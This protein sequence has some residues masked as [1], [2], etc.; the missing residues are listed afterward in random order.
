MSKIAIITNIPA[1]YRVDLF[2]YLQT[3]INEH[4]FHVIYTSAGEDNRAWTV[5]EEKMRNTRIL[6]TRVV[7]LRGKLDT[8]YI[9]LPGNVGN[10]LN[11]L[12]PDAV[13]AS[14]YNPAAMQ[15]LLW[16]K[17]HRKK[18]IHW[19]DGTLHSERNIGT[20]Q[21]LTRK[22]ICANADACIA[23]STKAKEKLLAW[24]GAI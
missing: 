13:I 15:A 12:A 16:A 23:S 7:K 9:H 19:T 5:Q 4:S 6:D 20:V 21:K 22:I 24:E 8:R 17:T 11:E 2:Y 1:P 18:F 14:E 10:V 3:H